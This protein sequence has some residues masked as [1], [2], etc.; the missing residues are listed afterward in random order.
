MIS[1]DDSLSRQFSRRSLLSS[2][3][4]EMEVHHFPDEDMVS[5]HPPAHGSGKINDHVSFKFPNP[6]VAP[7]LQQCHDATTLYSSLKDDHDLR[8]ARQAFINHLGKD[9]VVSCDL[10]LSHRLL[11]SL[12]QVWKIIVVALSNCTMISFL[13]KYVP[14]SFDDEV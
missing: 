4:F 12:A 5:F 10:L 13:A 8:S 7:S 9:L 3:P 14:L 6:N 1:I 2:G 11:L